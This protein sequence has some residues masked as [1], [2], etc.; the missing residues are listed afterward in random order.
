MYNDTIIQIII[1]I[2]AVS[3]IS[4]ILYLIFKSPFHYPYFKYSFDVS[5]KRKPDIDNL[6]DDFL[7]H[8]HFSMID[9]HEKEIECWKSECKRKIEKSKLKKYRLKQFQKALNDNEAYVFYLTREQTRY[10]QR[11]YIRTPYRV[12][13]IVDSFMCDYNYLLN[14]NEQLKNINY[15]CTIKE[16]NNKNQRKLMTNELRSKIIMRDKYTCQICGKYMPDEVGLHVDHIVPIS[17]GG[18][19]VPSNLQVL[20]SKCNGSKSNK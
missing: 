7:N 19:T 11:N 14:R 17:K 12:I 20:C 3:V 16:Y 9:K 10:V 18:K 5:G 8:K 4:F 6:I 2:G 1:G 15:E 13:Q